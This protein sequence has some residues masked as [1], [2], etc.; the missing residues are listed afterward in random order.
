MRY[1]AVYVRKF[2]LNQLET[3]DFACSN[4]LNY[5]CGSTTCKIIPLIILQKMQGAS[6]LRKDPDSDMRWI[7]NSSCTLRSV[8]PCCKTRRLSRTV[9]HAT[10][11]RTPFWAY[12]IGNCIMSI[13]QEKEASDS[14][15]TSFSKIPVMLAQLCLKYWNQIHHVGYIQWLDEYEEF[16]YQF[17]T[18]TRKR[19][20]G[21]L[22]QCWIPLWYTIG[23]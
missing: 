9:R 4:R 20:K 12:A 2:C 13:L 6:D 3:R 1:E 16:W 7:G 18:S 21:C 14:Q 8:R 23:C 15:P 19:D 17:E 22:Y 11:L 5:R 10:H